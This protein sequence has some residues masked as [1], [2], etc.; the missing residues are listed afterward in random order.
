MMGK[1]MET[2]RVIWK[3]EILGYRMFWQYNM[4]SLQGFDQSNCGQNA[5]RARQSKDSKTAELQVSR[6][7]RHS[8]FLSIPIRLMDVSDHWERVTVS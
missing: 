1:L 2:W 3:C 5:N 6:L 7:A 8:V 4:I